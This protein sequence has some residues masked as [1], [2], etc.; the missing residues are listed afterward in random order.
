M[1]TLTRLG[2]TYTFGLDTSLALGV[3]SVGMSRL[4]VPLLGA[5][6]LVLVAYA[7][8]RQL[9]VARPSAAPETLHFWEPPP[10]E[11][12]DVPASPPEPNPRI[13]EYY[14]AVKATGGRVRLVAK[15]K[16]PT[17][18]L[19]ARVAIPESSIV[20]DRGIEYADVDLGEASIRV[21]NPL[22]PGVSIPTRTPDGRKILA[23]PESSGAQL[24]SCVLVKTYSQP[25]VQGTFGPVHLDA[26]SVFDLRNMYDGALGSVSLQAP[27]EETCMSQAFAATVGELP[28]WTPAPPLDVK[29]CELDDCANA[30]A[31]W[32][33]AYHDVGVVL[34][35]LEHIANQNEDQRAFYW[36]QLWADED[37]NE[38]PNT[39]LGYWFGDYAD[40]RFEGI[41]SV[42]QKIYEVMQTPKLWTLPAGVWTL[43]CKPTLYGDCVAPDGKENTAYHQYRGKVSLCGERFRNLD[44]R[45]EKPRVLVH[46]AFHFKWIPLK[47]EW[48]E[49]RDRHFHESGAPCTRR[50]KGRIS[51]Y[52]RCEVLHLARFPADVWVFNKKTDMLERCGSREERTSGCAACSQEAGGACNHRDL[53]AQNNDTYGFATATIG[54]A[55]RLGSSYQWPP[56]DSVPEAPNATCPTD[57]AAPVLDPIETCVYVQSLPGSYLDCTNP[58]GGYECYQASQP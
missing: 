22:R 20:V 48:I 42:Y 38:V 31:G 1:R 39:S 13:R 51:D 3:A 32:M 57:L 26:V 12:P 55:L 19:N 33:R 37:G 17:R 29:E 47:G 45:F 4:L 7:I 41:L 50:P 36:N 28:D 5:A 15:P 46:E 43:T 23:I 14:D 8:G 24:S 30:Y 9:T 21:A 25:R 11:P 2:N 56:P 58:P 40:Y 34:Q 16:R 44:N 52:G 10:S 35:M 27:D 49:I 54:K 18:L 6:V 53:A